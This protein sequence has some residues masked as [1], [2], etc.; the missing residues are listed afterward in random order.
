[1]SVA[2]ISCQQII[3]HTFE[4]KHSM[5]ALPAESVSHLASPLDLGALR[6]GHWGNTVHMDQS[7]VPIAD[8]IYMFHVSL[9]DHIESAHKCYI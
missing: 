5:S 7:T 3:Q 4:L 2:K 1:M 8:E 9:D 6:V